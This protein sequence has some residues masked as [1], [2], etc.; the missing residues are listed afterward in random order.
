V[1]E[2]SE[3]LSNNHVHDAQSCCFA[4]QVPQF[5]EHGLQPRAIGQ[6][7][8]F[9]DMLVKRFAQGSALQSAITLAPAVLQ[10]AD[11]MK[12][13]ELYDPALTRSELD[14]S[15]NLVGDRGPD[16]FLDG[17]GD[18]CEC[19]R[20]ALHVLS[21][22]LKHRIEEDRLILMARLDRHHIQDLVFSSKTKVKSVQH[23]NQGSSRQM[24]TPRLRYELS[25]GP[26]EAPTQTLTGQAVAWSES[27][28][29]ASVQQHCL[30]SSIMRALRFAAAPFLADCPRALALTALTTSRS[31]VINFGF[32]TGRVR[33]R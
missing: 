3:K 33:V 19:P 4:K 6:L 26:T 12:M 27:L 30:Q 16:P 7:Q 32:A 5:F 15:R 31:E 22:W 14:N 29:G 18:G 8:S 2:A 20:P 11:E 23:Q 28:Q 9:A 10:S 21:A 1:I 13:A 24:Q 17:G 25:Q